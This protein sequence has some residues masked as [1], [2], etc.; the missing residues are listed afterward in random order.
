[1]I[2]IVLTVTDTANE[3]RYIP[4]LEVA[5]Y[6]LQFREPHWYQHRF[7]KDHDPDVQGARVHRRKL[8]SGAH[9]ALP[10]PA[11]RPIRGAQAV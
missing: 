7:L 5:G 10:R 3:A 4:D 2:D 11:T 9:A 1:V 6:V 8:G